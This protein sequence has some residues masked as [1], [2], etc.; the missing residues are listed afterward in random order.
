MD[1]QSPEEFSDMPMTEN[2]R[3]LK[4]GRMNEILVAEPMSV[5]DTNLAVGHGPGADA[6]QED[7]FQTPTWARCSSTCL[8]APR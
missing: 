2:G 7:G 6:E 1:Q 3:Y 5:S 4:G 8:S